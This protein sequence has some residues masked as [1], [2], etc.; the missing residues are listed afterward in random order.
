MWTC[1]QAKTIGRIVGEYRNNPAN[2]QTV[3]KTTVNELEKGTVVLI[4]EG[5]RMGAEHFK[6]YSGKFHIGFNG[7]VMATSL[8]QHRGV[9]RM[10]KS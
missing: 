2:E 9:G 8:W 6:A 7:D 1:E 3:L 10:K 5:C 4:V